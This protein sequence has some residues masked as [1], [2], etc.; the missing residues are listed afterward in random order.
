MLEGASIAV[1]VTAYREA[2][3]VGRVIETVPAFVDRIYA[4]DDA[5]PDDT[6]AEIRR[7]ADRVNED[8]GGRSRAREHSLPESRRVVPIRRA[9]NGG[10]GA[11]VKTGY[12]RAA[13]DGAD[14][15]AVMNGDGQMDPAI[16]ER[17]VTP[18]VRDEAEY[19]TGNRLLH[20]ADRREMGGVRLF[21]NAALSLLT[22]V[23]SGYWKLSDPQNGYTAISRET[24]EVLD[25]DALY[26]GFGFLNH[27]LIRLRARE[28]R[29]ADVAMPAVY[30][31]E[32][33]SIR[34][35]EFVPAVSR[36]LLRGYCGR[37][38][39]GARD[40]RPLV[41]FHALGASGIAGGLGGV[42]SSANTSTSTS[43]TSTS[44]SNSKS[45]P[46]HSH[47][48]DRAVAATMFVLGTI[49]L[50][51]GI[52]LEMDESR[53]LEC[54]RYEY[55]GENGSGSERGTEA[56]RRAGTHRAERGRER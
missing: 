22:K 49:A 35:R 29:V 9:V 37:L 26:D 33:S 2:A 42:L 4:V 1:V 30:G 16:L 51:L 11:T 6:W 50:A 46:A 3:S 7:V 23:G 28:C 44:G 34:Y 48:S 45:E 32:K 14:V 25:L 31:D 54:R 53:G 40:G 18:V 27:L 56:K 55:R 13:A 12:A 43:T 38:R 5:S 8:W 41:G 47:S 17:I 21:G 52:D 24:I 19:A 10:Y 39:R 36:I 15:V 20:P